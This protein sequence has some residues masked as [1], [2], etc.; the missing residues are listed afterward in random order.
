[1]PQHTR[2]KL[3]VLGRDIVT[4]A[5]REV[6]GLDESLNIREAIVQAQQDVGCNTEGNLV[7]QVDA[8]LHELI[9]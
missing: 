2:E 3:V 4:S 6:L 8:L 7:E 5:T 9:G 1:M